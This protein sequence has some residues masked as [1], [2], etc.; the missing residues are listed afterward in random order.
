M[1]ECNSRKE[2]KDTLRPGDV[3]RSNAFGTC[4][5]IDRDSGFSP[6]NIS[7]SVR[8]AP[9]LVFIIENNTL[10]THADLKDGEFIYPNACICKDGCG[11]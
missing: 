4:V 11:K 8:T 9:H 1:K 10:A 5:V 7:H 2:S 3:F 6:S